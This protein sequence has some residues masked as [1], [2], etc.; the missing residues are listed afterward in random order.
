MNATKPAPSGPANPDGRTLRALQLREQRRAHILEAAVEVFSHNGYHQTRIADIIDAAGIARGTFYLYFESKSAIFLELLGQLLKTLRTSVGKVDLT[1][2][3]TPVRDQLLAAIE[4]I[5]QVVAHNRA[6]TTIVMREAVGID[7]DVDEKLAGF[8]DSLHA[9]LLR[10]LSRGNAVGLIR[11]MDYEV[12][13]TCILGSV[14]QVLERDLVRN[15]DKPF[16]V[17]RVAETILEY[18]T[19]GLLEPG[20]TF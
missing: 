14:R 2:T 17:H 6:L 7:A 9:L 18:N 3:S 5:L 12:V 20:L 13:A 10:S 11:T 16:D 19:R 4:R 15:A 1:G 8:Y